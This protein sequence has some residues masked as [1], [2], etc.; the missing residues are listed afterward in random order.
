LK[1]GTVLFAAAAERWAGVLKRR[2]E[3]QSDQFSSWHKQISTFSGVVSSE[4]R[5]DRAEEGLLHDQVEFALKFK[6]VLQQQLVFREV[7]HP[8]G[9]A[10]QGRLGNIGYIGMH[11]A[12]PE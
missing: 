8:C 9:K 4:L 1:I 10:L 3:E 5:V 2:I 11:K 12:F 6:K 7:G